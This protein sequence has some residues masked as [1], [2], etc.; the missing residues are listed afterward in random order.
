[1]LRLHRAVLDQG[2]SNRGSG[3]RGLL[4]IKGR[5][6]NSVRIESLWVLIQG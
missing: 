3:N 2:S 4:G 5:V 6:S 1:M